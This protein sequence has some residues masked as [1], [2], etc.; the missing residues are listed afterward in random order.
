M[1]RRAAGE[2]PLLSAVAAPELVDVSAAT[3]RRAI[4]SGALEVAGDVG[5]RPRVRRIDVVAWIARGR[6]PP[7]LLSEGGVVRPGLRPRPRRRVLRDAL[8]ERAA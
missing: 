5:S 3:V 8:E 1:L 4:R 7:P 2:E 6:R